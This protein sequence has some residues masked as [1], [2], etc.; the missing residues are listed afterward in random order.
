MP[1]VP[2]GY[3]TLVED[4]AKASGFATWSNPNTAAIAEASIA[5]PATCKAREERSEIYV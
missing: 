1:L 3:S 5:S 4:M 2:W